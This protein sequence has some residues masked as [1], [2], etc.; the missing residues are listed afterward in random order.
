VFFYFPKSFSDKLARAT[1]EL[2][3]NKAAS[4]GEAIARE[5]DVG[6]IVY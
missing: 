4:A 6:E 5:T 1:K 2:D 3:E